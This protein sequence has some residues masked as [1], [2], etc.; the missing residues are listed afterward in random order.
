M[1]LGSAPYRRVPL[2][3]CGYARPAYG[4]AV[5]RFPEVAPRVSGASVSEV[6]SRS[7]I[8]RRNE[9]LPGTDGGVS[10]HLH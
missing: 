10:N 6:G 5:R 7:S 1:L 8:P 2:I 9:L 3:G 4:E